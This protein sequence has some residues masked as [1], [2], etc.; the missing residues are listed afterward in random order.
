[1]DFTTDIGRVRLLVA[2]L[3]P[4]APCFTDEMYQALLDMNHG[5][6]NLAAA[7]ALE[8]LAANEALV[9]KRIRTQDVQTD[10][11]AVA[12]ELRAQAL[13]L[14]EQE[15]DATYAF[16]DFVSFSQG[17]GPEAVEGRVR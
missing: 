13:R 3:D 7:T 9:S 2:D 11:P 16:F 10:G 5:S 17:P 15:A 6:V 1:M 12:A 14:R 4:T 8:T